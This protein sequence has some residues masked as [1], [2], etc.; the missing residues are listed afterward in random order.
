MNPVLESLRLGDTRSILA[1]RYTGQRFGT[2]WHFHPEHELTFI[3]ASRG[4]KFVGDHVGP[5]QPDELVLL[6]A[7][8]PHCWKNHATEGSIARSVVIQWTPGIFGSAPELEGL[9]TML[10][11]AAHG[12]LFPPAVVKDLLPTIRQLPELEGSDLFLGLLSVLLH[13]A[14]SDRRALSRAGFSENLSRETGTRMAIVHDFVEANYGRKV[15]L[16]EIAGRVNMSEQ[17]FS[18]FFSKMMGRPFFT[19]LN[20]YR[21][22]VAGRLLIDTERS[23]S[24]IG[25][26]CGYDSPP[27]FYK[28][29]AKYQGCSPGAYRLRYDPLR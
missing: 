20:E 23:V 16:A 29:F 1:F 9:K 15:S 28:Q 13:L 19:F 18:R 25:Y 3:E 27:F 22:N 26:A 8:V 11:A 4:T 14:E 21:I 7:N 10:K 17:S 6:R 5:Y 24:E 2:P 12:L